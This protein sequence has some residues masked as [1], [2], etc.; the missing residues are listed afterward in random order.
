MSRNRDD[1]RASAEVSPPETAQ[2]HTGSDN[3]SSNSHL[4]RN[5]TR[6]FW[7]GWEGATE[8]E[9]TTIEAN[10]WNRVKWA[11][12]ADCWLW[13]GPKTR[14]YGVYAYTVQKRVYRVYAHRFRWLIGESIPDRF[15]ACHA[16]DTPLCC[17]KLHLFVGTQGDNLRDASRKG[18]LTVPRTKKLTLADRIAIQQSTESGVVLAARYGVTETCISL[19]RRGRF[20][21]SG[22]S[23]APKQRTPELERV[24][25]V[26]LPV[27]GE[28]A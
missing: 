21:G 16:C 11:S 15:V 13:D 9:R 26:W 25:C 17:N 22:V 8:D 6:G 7:P 5:Q 24:P 2:I 20:V 28:V 14:G 23:F 27:R 12:G 10:F 19:T 18:R 3:V 1:L 4:N